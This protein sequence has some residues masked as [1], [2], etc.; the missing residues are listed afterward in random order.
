MSQNIVSPRSLFVTKLFAS[1]VATI[2]TA[3]A[4][5]IIDMSKNGVTLEKLMFIGISILTSVGV[6]ADKLEKDE[7]VFTPIGLPGRDKSVAETIYNN[8][9]LPAVSKVIAEMS[10]NTAQIAQPIIEKAIS[11]AVS[12]FVND[13]SDALK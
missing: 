12:K 7:S 10:P 11:Q 1:L 3:T 5:T 4:P 8:K 13:P 6:M 9:V 2:L